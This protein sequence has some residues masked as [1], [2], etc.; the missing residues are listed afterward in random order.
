MSTAQPR[1]FEPVTQ[2]LSH[3]H[4]DYHD[5]PLGNLIGI[6]NVCHTDANTVIDE[7]DRQRAQLDKFAD[8]D[9]T[10]FDGFHVLRYA[11]DSEAVV[12]G[13]FGT[14]TRVVNFFALLEQAHEHFAAKSSQVGVFAANNADFSIKITHADVTVAGATDPLRAYVEAVVRDGFSD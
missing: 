3:H 9:I 12:A 6:T 5:M 8:V 7:F 13:D 11:A 2:Y 14:P 10:E 4:N 1:G